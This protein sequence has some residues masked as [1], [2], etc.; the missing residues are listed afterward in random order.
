MPKSGRKS[1]YDTHV[2]PKLAEITAWAREGLTEIQICRLLG[3]GKTA[4]NQYKREHAELA[5]AIK[6][7]RCGLVQELRDTLIKKARG[8][9]YCETKEIWENGVLVKREVYERYAQ[10]D[11][12]AAHLLLKNYD[13][14]NWANDPRYL[15]LKEREL[16]LKEKAAEN[17][18]W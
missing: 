12:G 1:K 8:Y 15:A 2:A 11:T 6:T 18:G 4:F 17:E 7:G 10:P 9:H 14:E 3:I 13:K 5:D 16:E